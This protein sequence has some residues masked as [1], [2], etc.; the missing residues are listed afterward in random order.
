MDDSF[1]MVLDGKELNHSDPVFVKH[2]LIV[3]TIVMGSVGRMQASSKA[4]T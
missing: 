2:I 1:R 3:S 4:L